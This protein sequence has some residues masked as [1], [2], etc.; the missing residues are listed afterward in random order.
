M[1]RIENL[2]FKYGDVCVLDNFNLFVKKGEFV[3]IK[4]KSGSGKTTLLRLI[5]GLEEIQ[6]GKI[7]IN[8]DDVSKVPAYKRNVGFIFQNFALF[9]HLSVKQNI[10][11]GVKNLSKTERERKLDYLTDLFE[12][13]DYLQ[14]YPHEISQ[15]QKQRVA[16]SRAMICSP[17]VLLFDEPFTALDSDIKN[18]MRL[19]IKSIVNKLGIT[20]MMV[21]HD[22]KD[23]DIVC[24]RKIIFE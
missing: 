17:D 2:T 21:S 6:A 7:Y 3:G 8:G 1:I 11:F 22:D 20:C 13:N 19:E 12:I 5:S 15:G 16:V 24:D 10:L 18:K 9:P 4:G 14:R 23:L